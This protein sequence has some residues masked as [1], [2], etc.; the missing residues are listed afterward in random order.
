ML[1]PA[2]GGV[3]NDE[4]YFINNPERGTG[5]YIL[6]AVPETLTMSIPSRMTS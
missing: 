2:K 3:R 5:L 1:H 4:F 6:T